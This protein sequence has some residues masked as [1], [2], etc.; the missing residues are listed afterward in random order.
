MITKLGNKNPR[1]PYPLSWEEQRYL[2]KELPPYLQVM[3]LYKVNS[4]SRDQEV[5]KLEWDW[6]IPIPEINA[7][8]FL[9]PEDFGGRTENSGVKN[10]EPRVIILNNVAKSIIDGLWGGGHFVTVL[11]TD[12]FS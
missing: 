7:C 11:N 2:L 12:K 5:C 4:G 1:K 10:G 8:I 3:A 9:A 6:E